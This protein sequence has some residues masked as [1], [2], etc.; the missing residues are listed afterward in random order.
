[1]NL[2]FEFAGSHEHASFIRKAPSLK[3]H[4]CRK[5]SKRETA[6]ASFNNS[7]AGILLLKYFYWLVYEV[8]MHFY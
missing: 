1:M 2:N 8:V 5:M 6:I 4:G 7:E 3:E